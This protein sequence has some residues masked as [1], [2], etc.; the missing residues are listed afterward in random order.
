[1]CHCPED[2]PHH[3]SILQQTSEGKNYLVL[4]ESEEKLKLRIPVKVEDTGG[5]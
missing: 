2:L 5:Q 3:A 4:Y 1:M